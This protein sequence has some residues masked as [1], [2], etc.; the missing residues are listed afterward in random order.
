MRFEFARA[1]GFYRS[2][3]DNLHVPAA[4][5]P[6]LSPELFLNWERYAAR[7]VRC[8]ERWPLVEGEVAT[9]PWADEAALRARVNSWLRLWWGVWL[10]PSW[11]M[12]RVAR[13]LS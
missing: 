7:Y 12:S 4:H 9:T 13:A 6:Q 10:A 2:Y 11:A 3:G 8:A 5:Y 1:F